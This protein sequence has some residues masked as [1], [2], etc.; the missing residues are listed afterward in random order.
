MRHPGMQP[1][2][3]RINNAGKLVL[4][5]CENAPLLVR[6]SSLLVPLGALVFGLSQSA[7]GELSTREYRRL[8]REAP[9]DLR[10]EVV[11]VHER[12]VG[13]REREFD[14]KVE[15]K[16]L[17]IHRSEARIHEGDVIRINY[18]HH[19]RGRPA[20]GPGEPPILQRGKAYPAFLAKV[21]GERHYRPYAGTYSF[22]RLE[23][24]RP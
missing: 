9:E 23:E 1:T 7:C 15:A 19:R 18:V 11:D 10:I 17:R 14:I 12:R 21:R 20:P 2:S 24:R 16:V 3:S 6:A 13:E 5:L 4:K 22:E 8:Q